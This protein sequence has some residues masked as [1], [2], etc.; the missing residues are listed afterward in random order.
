MPFAILMLFLLCVTN[1][2]G[3]TG[4]EFFSRAS[5][6]GATASMWSDRDTWSKDSCGGSVLA[7]T[8]QL[9]GSRDTVT[10]CNGH[11]VEYDPADGEI[12]LTDLIIVGTLTTS[13]GKVLY[14]HTNGLS[15]A[16]PGSQLNVKGSGV[17][18]TINN[19]TD[20]N[21]NNMPTYGIKRTENTMVK[22]VFTGSR[23]SEI[24]LNST[25]LN[26][27]NS[28]TGITDIE[29][30]GSVTV[31]Q[32]TD[33]SLNSLVI[34]QGTYL[35]E[36]S[37]NLK[38]SQSLQNTGGNTTFQG[39]VT[40]NIFGYSDIIVKGD[41]VFE[42]LTLINSSNLHRSIFFEP[43][44]IIRVN[45]TF[46][47]GNSTSSFL[48]LSSNFWGKKWYLHLTSLDSSSLRR[49]IVCNSDASSSSPTLFPFSA[50]GGDTTVTLA[51]GCSDAPG[52]FAL[53]DTK[54]LSIID[55]VF[56]DVDR[57]QKYSKDDTLTLFLSYPTNQEVATNTIIDK[58][59]IDSLFEFSHVL[60]KH[61]IGRWN[62]DA[63]E[64]V[65]TIVDPMGNVLKQNV[66]TVKL[67]NTASLLYRFNP[68]AGGTILS[69]T[70]MLI[71]GNLTM[72]TGEPYIVPSVFRA[73]QEQ[74]IVFKN[75][76]GYSHIL[77]YDISGVLQFRHNLSSSVTDFEWNVKTNTNAVQ[78]QVVD[79]PS[80][81]YTVIFQ[82]NNKVNTKTN[83]F[84]VVR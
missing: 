40:L 80:G 79:L 81:V 76:Q 47:A 72:E 52:W 65:I 2:T 56:K 59:M 32:T 12:F 5:S 70:A 30:N 66:S 13:E 44:K 27:S 1:I 54:E 61:Y 67:K 50:V 74:S 60:G 73:S 53:T 24:L 37:G 11:N 14:I 4:L 34:K 36:A 55:A 20:W 69:D 48:Q 42:D 15:L 8:D 46:M 26:A 49:L 28:M 62:R 78:S 17:V 10:I 3:L 41:W 16:S 33:L 45:G 84:I 22:L 38:I 7:S 9:P 18:I 57:N 83:R 64:L 25:L 82:H 19:L 39:L 31:R 58:S 43:G 51:A 6:S 35:Q 29:L 63:S 71:E 68:D 77:V 21:L 75:I 23:S